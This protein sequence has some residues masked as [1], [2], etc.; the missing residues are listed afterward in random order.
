M[1]NLKFSKDEITIYRDECDRIQKELGRS[2]ESNNI[3]ICVT[4]FFHRISALCEDLI[5]KNKIQIA[6]KDGC[7]FCCRN[8]RVE[9][10]FPE[11]VTI[12]DFLIQ[13]HSNP[14]LE[15]IKRKLHQRLFQSGESSVDIPSSYHRECAFL[16]NDRCSIYNVRP[17]NCRQFHSIDVK[18]C[19]DK[20]HNP[21]TE[22][23]VPVNP[24]LQTKLH[25]VIAGFEDGFI[26][27]GFKMIRY[28]LHQALLAVLDD[29]EII[30][31][32]M[33]GYKN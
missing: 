22:L 32:W 1:S 4:N 10:F 18:V 7:S 31:N 20:F 27:A 6:C 5:H 25:A 11:I 19:E 30:D 33:R 3:N 8:N 14:S 26:Q 12:S 13:T 2:K 21:S 23:K 24:E 17:A 9:V 29:P 16:E 15:R 28:E